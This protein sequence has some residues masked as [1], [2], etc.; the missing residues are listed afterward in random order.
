MVIK[1]IAI[2]DDK[3]IISQ[4][5]RFV[6]CFCQS[7]W[8]S[9]REVWK[10]MIAAAS[11]VCAY[12]RVRVRV[13]MCAPTDTHRHICTGTHRHTTSGTLL[14]RSQQVVEGRGLRGRDDGRLDSEWH[15][16][17]DR[18]FDPQFWPWKS[19]VPGDGLRE[20]RSDERR[21]TKWA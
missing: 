19:T 20:E 12:I 5:R 15:P 17:F 1:V 10:K 8:K 14:T 11:C 9:F 4:V 18:H 7:F 6:K 16:F 2:P 3:C 13:Y 21:R